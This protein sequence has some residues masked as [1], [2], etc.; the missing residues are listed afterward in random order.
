MIKSGTFL[1]RYGSNVVHDSLQRVDEHVQVRAVNFTLHEE[2][3][4]GRA[5]LGL[6]ARSALD[7][8]KFGFKRL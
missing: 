1:L 4:V 6:P 2:L 7:V 8:Q 5:V 3:Q